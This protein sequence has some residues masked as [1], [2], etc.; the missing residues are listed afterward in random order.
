M[1]CF[2]NDFREIPFV[3]FVWFCGSSLCLQETDPRN[4]T[5]NHE[6]WIFLLP[7]FVA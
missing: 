2:S 3:L 6:I 1:W 4:H 7:G 5:N